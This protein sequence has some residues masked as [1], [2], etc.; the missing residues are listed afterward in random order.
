MIHLIWFLRLMG[1]TYALRKILLYIFIYI[2]IIFTSTC[3]CHILFIYYK[4]FSFISFIEA[5][6]SAHNALSPS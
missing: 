5:A 1:L 4:V 6:C 3:I 2:C